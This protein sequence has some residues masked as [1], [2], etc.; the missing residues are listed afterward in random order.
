MN[1][2]MDNRWSQLGLSAVVTGTVAALVSAAALAAL[3]KMEGKGAL[4]PVNATSHWMQ[5]DEAAKVELPSARHTLVGFATHHASAIFWAAPFEA[6]LAM[7]PP[8]SLSN[9]L[10]DAFVMSGVAALVDYGATPHRL[11]PGWELVLSKKSMV[12]SYVALAF[13]LAA[14]AL[15]SDRVRASTRKTMRASW[16]EAI[17]QRLSRLTQG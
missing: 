9:L 5:G 17:P 3:A 12:A 15:V 4:Q 8:R 10:R 16:R 14:G 2:V 1:R 11:T 7:N 13:G 6:W